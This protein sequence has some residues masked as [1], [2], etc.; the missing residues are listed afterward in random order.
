MGKR[1]FPSKYKEEIHCVVARALASKGYTVD[2]I[3]ESVNIKGETFKNWIDTYPELRN[4]YQ[5]GK[6]EYVLPVEN[7]LMDMINDDNHP[8]RQFSALQFY[9]LSRKPAM[10]RAKKDESGPTNDTIIIKSEDKDL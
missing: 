1:G 4:A 2:Q 8:A 7:K 10:Y 6:N 9:L 5:E 3:A